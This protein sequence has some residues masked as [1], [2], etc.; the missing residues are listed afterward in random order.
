MKSRFVEHRHPFKIRATRPH[1]FKSDRLLGTPLSIVIDLD[2]EDRYQYPGYKD[3]GD[4]RL[5]GAD[6]D[7]RYMGD[8]AG[9]FTLSNTSRQGAARY[10]IAMLF[11]LGADNDRYR[12]LRASQGY[13]HLGVGVLFDDGGDDSYIAEAVSQGA[14]QFG[15][16]LLIDA[17]V[18]HDLRLSHTES[19]G[20]GF[21][22]GAGVLLD[23][24]GSD[25]YICV[26]G[27]IDDFSPLYP[28][29]QVVIDGSDSLCQGAGFGRRGRTRYE[30]LAG[31]VGIL[32]DV[33]GDDSYEAGVFAQGVGFW[34]GVG[35]LSD[36]AGADEYDAYYYA[37][38]AAAHY[39]I[40]LLSDD[41]LGG[42]HFNLRTASR[43]VQ[44]GSGHDF[45]VGALLN[46]T[47]D[48]VYRFAG[49]SAGASN[50]NGIGLFIDNGGNDTY[51]ATSDYGSGMGNV[52]KKCAPNRGEARSIGIMIDAGGLDAYYYPSSLSDLKA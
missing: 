22:G 12:S 39:A 21:A 7:G 18:G 8:K 43:Y 6:S 32:R 47:G 24:G 33:S 1:A 46:E 51:Q 4:P 25:R 16:G 17:G 44:L 41:G 28:S 48:D 36:G 15:I 14:G 40:G 5:L 20:F 26:E 49:L 31:G 3:D 38:G 27:G 2:G 9:P 10:G 37:Q 35:V 29:G 19:Q 42:D 30:H 11:D 45:S 23:G 50:C 52:G 13:A 34:Q